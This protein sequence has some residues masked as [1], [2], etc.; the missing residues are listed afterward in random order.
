MKKAT[1]IFI[2][3]LLLLPCTAFGESTEEPIESGVD[4]VLN[5]EAVD[6]NEIDTDLKLTEEDGASREEDDKKQEEALLEL[7]KDADYIKV[8]IGKSYN[9]SERATIRSDSGFALYEDGTGK[10][11]VPIMEKEISV[12]IGIGGYNQIDVYSKGR[13]LLMIPSDGKTIFAPANDRDLININGKPYRDY[14]IFSTGKDGL[15]AI[16]YIDMEKYLYGVVPREIPSSSETEALKA[17]AV[18][19]RSYAYRAIGKHSAEGYDMCDTTHCQVHGGYSGEHSRTNH[20]IEETRGLV[21]MYGRDI[22]NTFFHSSSGGHTASS[23]EV[24]GGKLPY[25]Q[26]VDDPYS[27][28]AKNSTWSF[29]LDAEDFEKTLENNGVRAGR[30]QDIRIVETTDSGRVKKIEI[31][32]ERDRAMITGEKLRAMISYSKIKSTLFQL[33]LEYN[34]EEKENDQNTGESFVTAENI[35]VSYSYRGGIATTIITEN[36]VAVQL[37]LSAGKKE[38]AGIED[39]ENANDEVFVKSVGIEGSGYGHGVGMS[40]YGAMEMAILG[41][42]FEEILKHYYQSVDIRDIRDIRR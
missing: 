32:G 2:V 36:P 29:D 13:H 33:D 30:I 42:N 6:V 38:N 24:W 19:A 14:L 31:I 12:G 10:L 1:Y 21:A 7:N 40:Q 28:N 4:N 23:E 22:A 26:G 27:L 20:A 41:F 35:E 11:L 5:D 34:R 16:N 8:K 37:P 39:A 18:A 17:Q 25:L 3:L 9:I 15:N